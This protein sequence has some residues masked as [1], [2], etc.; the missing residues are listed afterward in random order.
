MFF[1]VDGRIFAVPS[2]EIELTVE[3]EA[4]EISH[5]GSDSVDQMGGR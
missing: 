3:I 2:T 4:I 1:A 5:F